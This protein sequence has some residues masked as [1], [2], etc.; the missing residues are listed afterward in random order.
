MSHK[1]VSGLV[2]ISARN[3]EPGGI[4]QN[5]FLIADSFAEDVL[6]SPFPVQLIQAAII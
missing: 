2:R 1:I 3:T 6:I 5:I 4:S